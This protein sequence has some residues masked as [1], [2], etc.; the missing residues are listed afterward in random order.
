[1]TWICPKC[2]RSFKINHQGHSCAIFDLAHHFV[3][4][5]PEFK[6]IF[7]E[8]KQTLDQVGSYQ[9]SSLKHVILFSASSNFLAV[10]TKKEWIELEVVLPEEILEFPIHKAIRAS[11][12]QVAHFIRI[13]HINEV[14]DQLK[15]WLLQAIDYN[16]KS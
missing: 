13:Q 1:M 9:I 5:N 15:R 12:R 14:D 16:M 7:N 3:N 10:K 11:K 4:R 6:E 2:K 8:I